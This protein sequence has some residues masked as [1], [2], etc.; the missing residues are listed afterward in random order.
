MLG[1]M[2]R[3]LVLSI[4]LLVAMEA[5]IRTED[6]VRYGTEWLS[7]YRDQSELIVHDADGAH[8]RRGARF[9]KWVLDSL[10][11]RGP[12][13]DSAR[14]ADVLRVVTTGASETFGLYE[15]DNQEYPRQLQDTLEAG[16]IA[17][18]CTGVSRVEVLNAAMPGMSLP[19][20]TQDVR[21]RLRR[22]GPS[23][24]IIYPTPAQYLDERVPEAAAPDSVESDPLPG[25]WARLY[26]RLLDRLREQ[27][28]SLVPQA[29]QDRLRA[30]MISKEIAAHE[31]GWRFDSVPT[32]RLGAFESDLRAFV[33]AV[34]SIG[35]EP[36]LA[37]HA[38]AFAPDLPAD[39]S[40]VRKWERF[41]PRATGTTIIEFDEAAA[42][43]I[44]KVAL[45]S[46]VALADVRGSVGPAGF[47]D[48]AHFNN[49][50]A[51]RVASTLAPAAIR[52]AETKGAVS[53]SSG[54][55]R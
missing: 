15:S 4:T 45:D 50:G 2:P 13:V 26:P 31:P 3:A 43:R 52:A 49:F 25:W 53:C 14:P 47:A 51:G 7:P 8:G 30:R 19:T 29:A 12:E 42:A 37:T 32:G 11:F 20:V 16:I 38:N 34:R 35:A 18:K 33:G 23:V 41:Y 55:V 6:W 22:F 17:Y 54:S 48:Y 28:K 36:V 27:A 46:S 39:G 9:Q 10:G 44:R 40:L 1:L 24:V 21:L 5:T